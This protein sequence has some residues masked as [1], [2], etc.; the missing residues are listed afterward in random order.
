MPAR[1]RINRS[2]LSNEIMLKMELDSRRPKSE[3][4]LQTKKE[5]ELVAAY[6]RDVAWPTSIGTPPAKMPNHGYETGSYRES[7]HVEQLR[8]AK[9]R[10][11]GGRRG[12]SG[13]R[14]PAFQVIT[15]HPNANF[16]EFGT[17][18]DKP[19][20]RSPWGPRTPTPEFAPAA[21]T[22]HF[23]KGTAP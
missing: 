17:G 21:K 23:F 11:T 3:V 12:V 5:A 8:D 7:I 14:L 20:S 22:A 6:W 13:R 1:R 15:R 2:K 4:A 10:F 19:G 18:V 9:G 16:I